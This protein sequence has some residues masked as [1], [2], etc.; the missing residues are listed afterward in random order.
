MLNFLSFFLDFKTAE[1][2][3]ILFYRFEGEKQIYE[4]RE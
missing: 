3:I 2:D 4:S 1:E